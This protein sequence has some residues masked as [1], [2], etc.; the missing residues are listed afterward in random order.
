M[1]NFNLWSINNPCYNIDDLNDFAQKD[2]KNLIKNCEK[3]YHDQINEVAKNIQAKKIKM[4]LVAGPSSAGKT[5]TSKILAKKLLSYNIGSIVISMDDF[6][7]DLKDT[8]LLEDGNPDFDNVSTVDIKEFQKFYKTLLT[9]KKAEKPIYNF[10]KQK[11]D[12]WETIKLNENSVIIV[13]GLHALNPIFFNEDNLENQIYRIYIN[14]HSIFREKD[15]IILSPQD[16]RLVRRIYRDY[17]TRDKSPKQTLSFWNNV[18]NAE[19]KYISPFKHLAD[20]FIDTTIAYEVLIYAHCFTGILKGY[21][22]FDKLNELI[23][24][25]EKLTPLSKTSIPENSLL[26]E[27]IVNKEESYE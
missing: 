7:L 11:R 21:E 15:K 22:D 25:F 8:P 16:L 6:F 2:A 24:I 3:I 12:E 26:W 13:E 1:K 9:Q 5:T 10:V 23:K 4:V 14:S 19:N 27:F 20:Y 18:C 17:L